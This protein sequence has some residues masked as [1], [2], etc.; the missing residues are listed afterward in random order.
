MAEIGG[1]GYSLLPQ[2]GDGNA[3]FSRQPIAFALGVAEQAW[4]K[5]RSGCVVP[6]QNKGVAAQH[7]YELLHPTQIEPT[8]SFVTVQSCCH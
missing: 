4:Q 8:A 6:M 5:L 2:H 3:G 1:G 7:P